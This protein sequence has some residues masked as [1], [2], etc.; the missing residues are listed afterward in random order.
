MSTLMLVCVCVLR[1]VIIAMYNGSSS[2]VLVGVVTTGVGSRS[3]AAVDKT[4]VIP[5]DCGRL[6]S[7]IKRK[8]GGHRLGT[9]CPSSF[10]EDTLKV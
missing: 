7:L 4:G 5:V 6:P 8:I 3:A 2:E 1:P 9:L 10:S